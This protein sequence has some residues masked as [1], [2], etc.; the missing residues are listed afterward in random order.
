MSASSAPDADATRRLLARVAV[1]LRL[2]AIG[3][4]VFL[5]V[6]VLAGV[7]GAAF[8][9]SR[10]LA[11]LPDWFDPMT[12]LAVPATAGLLALLFHR[13]PTTTGA[14]RRVDEHAGTKDLFLTTTM[15]E[16]A[17]GEFK[18]LVVHQAEERA[19]AVRPAKVVPYDWHRRGA[20]CAAV[21]GILLLA[22]ERMPQLDPFGRH[23]ER[24]KT[25]RL[26]R[27]L[28]DSRKATALRIAQ[29]KKRKPQAKTSEEARNALDDLKKTFNTMKPTQPKANLQRLQTAQQHL[30][31]LWKLRSEQRLKDAFD[32]G[33]QTQTLGANQGT[34]AQQWKRSLQ[35]GDPS[36]IQK[37]I[38]AIHK[39]IAQMQKSTDPVERSR[40]QQEVRQRLGGLQDF[41]ANNATSKPLQEAARRALEQLTAAD[42]PQLSK[43]AL[44][45]L[46]ESLDQA[47]LE[48]DDV[49]QAVRD[50]QAL[51]D[52]LRA[53][54][55][56]KQAN[57]QCNGLN[58]G[59]CEGCESMGD[60][61]DFYKQLMEGK[62]T[63][64][65]GPGMGPK[66]IGKGGE[67]PEKPDEV[68]DYKSERS[69][70]AFQ[71]GKILLQWKTKQLSDPGSV[72]EARKH[73]TDIKQAATEAI[74]QEQVPPGYHDAIKRYFD[75]L[76]EA[77]DTP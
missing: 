61:A 62:D 51:E 9:A 4:L 46:K 35:K 49:A 27:D 45:A 53:A 18:P 11:L 70:S 22:V 56:A 31:E 14:A 75:S 16:G 20:L 47:K 21:L 48:L 1:R 72:T 37:E 50:L 58:G 7:Y 55:L 32:R 28:A 26:Q 23:E 74:L 54:Q 8:A 24:K 34:Q 43:E 15:L 40:L 64:K 66:G 10:L 12:L 59:D 44:Q 41:L 6:L 77:G 52:A 33:R 38:D 2:S 5:L 25:A 30:S 67:A 76:E 36:D 13:R 63:A 19:A 71:A 73:I 17:P 39:K 68:T 42:N 69:R 3:R 57:S 29:L 60:Y 65:I